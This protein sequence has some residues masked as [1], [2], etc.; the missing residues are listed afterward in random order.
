MMTATTSGGTIPDMADYAVLLEPQGIQVGTVNE[1]FAIESPGD[2][3]QLGNQSYRIIR[4]ETGR[5]RVEDA[6]GRRRTSRSGSA[7]R[8][9]AATN[10]RRQS[11]GCARGS[12]GCSPTA[13]G[14]DMPRR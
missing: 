8:R 13:S 6:Q 2:V 3:F 11:A 9:G 12:T 10:C 14:K 4:V 7:R 5:V 1:D